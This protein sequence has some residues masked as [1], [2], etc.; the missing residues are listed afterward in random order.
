MIPTE[1][2]EQIEVVKHLEKR[3]LKFTA[4]PNSTYTKSWSQKNKNTR[5]GLRAGLPDLLIALPGVG[6]LFI[7]MKRTKG[8]VTSAEQKAWIETINLCPGAQAYVCKGAIEA[9]AIIEK[10]IIK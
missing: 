1:E 8:S 7:E 10:Y 2:A 4:I 9:I 3:R 5:T 6:L